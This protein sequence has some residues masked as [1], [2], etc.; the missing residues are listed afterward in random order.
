[1]MRLAL[2]SFKWGIDPADNGAVI[3][4]IDP[5]C[6]ILIQLPFTEQALPDLI[7]ALATRLTEDQK[8]ELSPLFLSSGIQLPGRDFPASEPGPQG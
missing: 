6:N 8:R 3:N 4:A 2:T 5:E 7:S 1:M